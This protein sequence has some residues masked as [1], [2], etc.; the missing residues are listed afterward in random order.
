[1]KLPTFIPHF[2]RFYLDKFLEDLLRARDLQQKEAKHYL[3][4][5]RARLDNPD[6]IATESVQGLMIAYRDVQDYT[7]MID[8][9]E[10]LKPVSTVVEEPFIRFLYAFALAR[11][12]NGDKTNDQEKA[13]FHCKE[14]LKLKESFP[15]AY[16]LCGR[17]YKDRFVQSN[18]ED[19]ESLHQA[20]EWWVEWM[21][22]MIMMMMIIR[23][24]YSNV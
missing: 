19:T 6:V 1:M 3:L 2:S 10:D 15:D 13:L 21:V 18:Y 11:R 7:A 17:I 8:L 14:L 22:M 20:I 9:Y 4:G 23:L 16:G 5:M 12:Q 24:L